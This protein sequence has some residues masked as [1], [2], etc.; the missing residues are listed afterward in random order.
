[1]KFL[2]KHLVIAMAV[3]AIGMG[4]ITS[5]ADSGSANG[6]SPS[7]AVD[8]DFRVV[9]PGIMQFRVGTDAAGTIDEVLF[10]PVAGDVGNGNNVNATTSGTV[11]VS[12]FSNAGLITITPT[13]DGGGN[14]LNN[15]TVNEDIPYS[16]I[17]VSESN[18]AFANPTLSNAGGA[19][20]ATTPTP[21]SG[22]NKVTNYP[23]ETWA[24]IYDN[25]AV[26]PVG[27]YTGTVTYTA[28]T[29]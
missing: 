3:T 18:A 28:T 9:I 13:N 10:E 8:L 19:A 14:G 7:V 15:G 23:S 25:T 5:L 1:M 16:E 22:N 4:P 2:N 17:L 24:Y 26:Y 12:L 27:D 11:T 29:P 21:T 6:G 20:D